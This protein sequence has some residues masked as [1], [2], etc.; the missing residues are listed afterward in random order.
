MTEMR[1]ALL[2][3]ARG[4]IQ[5]ALTIY[6]SSA[7]G[8][9]D[10]SAYRCSQAQLE[11]RRR[12]T[13]SFL[14]HRPLAL[15]SVRG[16]ACPPAPYGTRTSARARAALATARRSAQIDLASCCSEVRDGGRRQPRLSGRPLLGLQRCHFRLPYTVR[17][18]LQ[19]LPRRRSAAAAGSSLSD[20][21]CGRD[22]M[23]GAR[24][25]ICAGACACVVQTSKNTD[26]RI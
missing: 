23:R 25:R 16:H 17:R 12:G 19:V 14:D 1:V 26:P 18:L 2:I 24:G 21:W 5:S 13:C 22:V 8:I 10:G 15:A 11:P 4:S 20:S 6:A 7:K 9:A 3:G